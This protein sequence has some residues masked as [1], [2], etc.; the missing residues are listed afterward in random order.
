ML[1]ATADFSDNDAGGTH[2]SLAAHWFEQ[3]KQ[4]KGVQFITYTFRNNTNFIMQ[5]KNVCGYKAV[6][7]KQ[8]LFML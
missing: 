8:Y 7:T 1:T 4:I 5:K 6:F 2:R 3:M